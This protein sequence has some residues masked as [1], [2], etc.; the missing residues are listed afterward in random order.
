MANFPV[1]HG[2]TLAANSYIENLHVEVLASDPVPVGPGRVWFNSTDKVFK[3][4]GVDGTGAVI[5]RTFKDAESAA[6]ELASVQASLATELARAKAAEGVLTSNLA[7]EAA[8]AQAAEATLDAKIDQTKQDILGG[9]APST[10]DTITEIA[11]ALRD[12]PSIVDVLEQKMAA[13]IQAAKD[14]LRGAVSASFDTLQEVEAGL[15][16]ETTARTQAVA[17]E[18]LARETADAALDARVTT[19][20]GQV[21]GKIGNLATLHTTKQSSL[22]EAINEVQDEIEAEVVRAQAAEATLTTSLGT[23][24]AR[25]QSAEATLT[26]NLA[27]EVTRAQAAEA[28]LTANL[29]SEVT[30]AQ[31]AEAA[32]STSL[33]AEVVRAQAAEATLTTN[34]ETEVTRALAAESQL[35][36]DLATEV[37]RAKAAEGDLATLNTT[38]KSS[39]VAAINEAAATASAGTAALKSQLNGSRFVFQSAAAA[40]THTIVHGLDSLFVGAT[41]WIE[42]NG[43]YRN[44]I[45]AMEEVDANTLKVTLSSS[46]KVKVVVQD[47]DQ[48]S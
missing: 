31:A 14:E 2:L 24:T 23:E 15:V 22:V 10:L 30:R 48:L 26:A 33:D 3:Y 18:T 28:T 47:L 46:A 41:L 20:E 39:L 17:A 38:A 32:L 6:T 42:R 4:S 36:T 29:A 45:A 7:A 25:A 5:V 11:A 44:D 8:R 27:S 37:T 13:D 35:G 21:N 43:T 1:F 19:V 9:I 40:S 12:N 16:A 34:L